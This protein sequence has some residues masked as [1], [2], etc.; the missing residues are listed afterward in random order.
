[1]L[2]SVFEAEIQEYLV[3]DW[4]RVMSHVLTV[5]RIGDF[6]DFFLKSM[7]LST[8]SSVV[9]LRVTVFACFRMISA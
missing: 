4:V 3:G 8:K 5:F 1:M 2:L 6:F 7:F 9:V